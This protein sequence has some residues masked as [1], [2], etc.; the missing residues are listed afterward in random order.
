MF[1]HYKGSI[2]L[3]YNNPLSMEFAEIVKNDK[4]FLGLKIPTR[5]K[6]VRKML[7][8]LRG[9]LRKIGPLFIDYEGLFL[10]F[11]IN[12]PFLKSLC[13]LHDMIFSALIFSTTLLK[14]LTKQ[15]INFNKA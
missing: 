6:I 7:S 2:G 15:R 3:G 12:K 4:P 14:K 9:I 1:I 10:I 5:V 13:I 8:L 11:Q